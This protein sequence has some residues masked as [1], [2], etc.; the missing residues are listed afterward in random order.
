MIPKGFIKP[1]DLLKLVWI[2][3]HLS[4][5][6][7]RKRQFDVLETPPLPVPRFTAKEVVEILGIEQWRLQKFLNTPKYKLSAEGQLGKGRGSRRL[8]S[9][10]D[11]HRLGVAHQLARD[12]FSPTFVAEAVQ[13]LEDEELLGISFGPKGEAQADLSIGFIC[14]DQGVKA[15]YVED[16]SRWVQ[17]D[18]F[19]FLN[20]PKLRKRIEQRISEVSK[21]RIAQ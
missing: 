12:G 9:T 17:L 19:Y 15:H 8:F 20:L 18:S 3:S 5:C 21:E 13:Q 1:Y 14:D 16:L 2:S 10:E 11:I 4:S 7:T 6:M